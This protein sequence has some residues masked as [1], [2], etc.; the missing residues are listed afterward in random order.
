[1]GIRE[2][3][4]VGTCRD[5][6]ERYTACHDTCEK[7]IKA[8]EEYEAKKSMIKSLKE[9]NNIYTNYKYKKILKECKQKRSK[10]G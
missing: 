2:F 3:K 7:Y 9:E 1:M 4:T 6:Q 5:C 10:K 8:K